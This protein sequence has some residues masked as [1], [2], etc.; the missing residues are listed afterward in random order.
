MRRDA[1]HSYLSVRALFIMYLLINCHSILLLSGGIPHENLPFG[2]GSYKSNT[3]SSVRL[4]KLGIDDF[5]PFAKLG[6]RPRDEDIAVEVFLRLFPSELLL[7]KD[8]VAI[9]EMDVHC[10]VEDST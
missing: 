10:S 9:S 7:D 2:I 5:G 1:H 8:G 6:Q 4:L 3:L